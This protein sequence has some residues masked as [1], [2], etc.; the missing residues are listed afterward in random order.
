MESVYAAMVLAVDDGVGRIWAELERQGI[1]DNTIIIF[2][3]DNGGINLAHNLPYRAWKGNM[4][5][6]GI[7]PSAIYWKGEIKAGTTYD[8]TISALDIFPTVATAAGVDV[9]TLKKPLDGVNLL[10][11]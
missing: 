6:G 3:S 2:L 5:E 4:F 11:C 1:D 7:R 8:K 10:L 9:T